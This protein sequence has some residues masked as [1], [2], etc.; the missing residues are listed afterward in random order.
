MCKLVDELKAR[1]EALKK[2]RTLSG[3]GR[4]GRI[5]ENKRTIRLIEAQGCKSPTAD[6]EGEKRDYSDYL[7]EH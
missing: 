7:R 6:T 3:L 5:A 4:A 1:N 2:D